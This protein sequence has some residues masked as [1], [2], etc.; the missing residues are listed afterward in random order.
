MGQCVMFVPV[1]A[2]VCCGH[3]RK[4]RAGLCRTRPAASPQ[5]PLYEYPR[6]VMPGLAVSPLF[7]GGLSHVC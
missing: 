2:G 4:K 3:T 5:F 7:Q 1:P 6:P